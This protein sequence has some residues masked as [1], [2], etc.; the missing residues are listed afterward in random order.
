M[1]VS[2]L[3]SS[4]ILLGSIIYAGGDIL[5]T[6]PNSDQN[7]MEEYASY[8]I[9]IDQPPI[10][11]GEHNIEI[12]EEAYV[13]EEQNIDE[14]YKAPHIENYKGEINPQ[15][16]NEVSP[17]IISSV[18]SN[19]SSLSSNSDRDK[20]E[21]VEDH[22]QENPN[23]I[24][25]MPTTIPARN[26]IGFYA[27]LG[28]T[29]VHY[30]IK[31]DCPN[32]SRTNKSLGAITKAGYNINKFIGVEARAMR[33]KLKNNKGNITHAGIFIKPMIPL[34]PNA[35]A[36]TL[37]GVAKTKS[38]GSLRKIDAETLAL[39]TGIEMGIGEKLSTFVDY[40]RLMM[41]SNAPKL[42]TL[43]TGMNYHF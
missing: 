6:T 30:K 8:T 35:N 2:K 12:V 20:R 33:L 42:E 43:S 19:A 15:N 4:S 3:L 13:Q 24:K 27:G 22:N 18:I 31:C 32:K 26:S 17:Y 21:F 38:S 16:T 29:A 11:V 36:Y 39:G 23:S 10:I 37:I 5:Y 28:I 40:E 7:S 25:T 1:R 9:S 34:T 41:K 14:A